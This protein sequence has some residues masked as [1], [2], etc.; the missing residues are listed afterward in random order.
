MDSRDRIPVTGN[1]LHHV[2]LFRLCSRCIAHIT[3]ESQFDCHT[4]F[5]MGRNDEN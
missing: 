3:M 5:D 2:G 4:P 1:M